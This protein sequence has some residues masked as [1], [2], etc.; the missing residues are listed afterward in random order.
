MNAGRHFG[1]ESLLRLATLCAVM[2]SVELREDAREG[3]GAS[4]CKVDVGRR[5][6]NDTSVHGVSGGDGFALRCRDI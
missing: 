4:G 5:R 6:N 3:L 2:E 1:D